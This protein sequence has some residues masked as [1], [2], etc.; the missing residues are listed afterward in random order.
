MTAF[1]A[2]VRHPDHQSV[3]TPDRHLFTINATRGWRC[4][5]CGKPESH[6]L[7]ITPKNPADTYHDSS[8]WKGL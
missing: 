6:A 7:H 1:A 8:A 2:L 3:A 4:V 5:I